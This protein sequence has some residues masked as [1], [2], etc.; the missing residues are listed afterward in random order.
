MSEKYASIKDKAS[1]QNWEFN[2]IRMGYA[3]STFEDFS[4]HKASNDN[5]YVR[6]HFGLKGD[7]Q[8]TYK[9]LDQSFDLAGGHH[10]LMYSKG[11]DLT[12]Q[13][14]TLEIETFGVDFPKEAFISFVN[15]GDPLLDQFVEQVIN[16]NSSILSP[17]W[18]TIDT[19][20]QQIIDE[21]LP[22][23]YTGQLKKVFLLAKSLEL[24]V[25]CVDNYK[26][27]NQ[28]LYR[29]IKTSADKEK[30]IAARD[31][32]NERMTSPPNLTEI[33]REVGLN[34][35]KLKHGF[36]EVFHSTVFEYLTGRRLNHA[37]QIL[38]DT[39]KTV[40]E[41]SSELVYSSPQHFHK[42]FVTKFGKTPNSIRKNP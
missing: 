1:T 42:Q 16:G 7:Y 35:F 12:I 14:K 18:G 23:P 32:I 24:L 28:T 11:I 9:Q 37:K 30:I 3:S 8:F 26:K 10:N 25:L 13:N 39:E 21:V 31:F 22:N 4:T 34:E 15:D 20:I 29:H 2:G 6:L 5:E 19:K 40:A 33:A 36:K 27:L 41:I 17:A 38:L